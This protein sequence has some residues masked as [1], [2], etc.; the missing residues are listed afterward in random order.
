E[1]VN[2]W[3]YSVA[4]IAAMIAP[5]FLGMVADR[6]FASERVLGVLMLVGA[7]LIGLAPTFAT[8]ESTSATMFLLCL[9]GHTLCFMPTL[10]LTNT[11]A[12][13]NMTNREKQ[14]PLIRV[15][16]TLGWIAAGLFISIVLKA[17]YDARPF[18]VAAA[19]A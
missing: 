3:A 6:F 1:W 18:Y 4:P 2:G 12:F 13:A 16:G 8:G 17:D 11:I 19:A 5:L 10:G 7:T 9:L 14:F 15:F